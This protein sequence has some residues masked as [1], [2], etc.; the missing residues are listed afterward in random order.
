MIW[1]R[2]PA[3]LSALF[4]LLSLLFTTAHLSGLIDMPS[5]IIVCC[6]TNACTYLYPPHEE[7]SARIPLQGQPSL[8]RGPL[9]DRN[10]LGHRRLRSA[11][12]PG[13]CRKTRC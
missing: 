12:P 5:L 11:L 4:I 8:I 3:G 13:E 6:D 9:K 1:P 10:P 2:P 7:R